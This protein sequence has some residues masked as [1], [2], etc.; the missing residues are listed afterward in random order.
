MMTRLSA[1]RLMTGAATLSIAALALTA[2]AGTG[3]APTSEAA[4]TGSAEKIVFWSNHPGSSK[5]IEEEIIAEWNEENPDT[6]VELVDAGANYEEVAQKFNASLAGGDLPDVVVASDVNWF[7]FA[8]NDNFAEMGPLWESQDVESD[9]LVDTLRDDYEFNDEHWA[10]PYA[11]STNLMYVNDQIF[12]EAGLPAEGFETWQDFAEAAP[13]LKEVTGDDPVLVIPDGSNYLDWYFQ[14]MIWTFG[15]AYSEDWT[16]TFTQPE[17]IEAGE[18]LQEMVQEGYIEISNDAVNTFGVGSAGA[19]LESTGSLGGLEETAAMD[20]TTVY[21]PGPT[22]GAATGGAGLAI[23]SG[24]SEERQANAVRFIDFLT[25]TDNTVKFSQAT[26]YMPVRKSALEHPDE[27][28]FL[29]ENPNAMTAI[30]QLNENTQP[31][32]AARVLVQGG[33]AR[34]GG[35][36][37]EI[38]TGGADVTEVFTRLEEE[39]QEIIDRDI[40]PKLDQQ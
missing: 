32:D 20:F 18:F 2:C 3:G 19:L 22:P 26:G 15:G 40:K 11:R 17:S 25:N 33:G 31:Q 9:D 7:N 37:D 5:D 30:E 14:G 28:A 29:E 1:R 24:I 23:P 8:M 13:A 21:L 10:M 35:A 6:P 27:V 16:A 39:T 38:T 34:I 4:D 12:E 36:L